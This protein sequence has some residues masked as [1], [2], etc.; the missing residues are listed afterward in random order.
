MSKLHSLSKLSLLH[1]IALLF[2]LSISDITPCYGQLQFSYEYG[3]G[4]DTENATDIVEHTFSMGSGQR[5]RKL[6]GI[7]SMD[8]VLSLST[9]NQA[10]AQQSDEKIKFERAILALSSEYSFSSRRVQPIIGIALGLGGESPENNEEDIAS[11]LVASGIGGIRV[12][13]TKTIAL[14]SMY[15]QTY[16]MLS[17]KSL[18]TTTKIVSIGL[19]IALFSKKTTL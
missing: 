4:A 12:Y 1:F 10:E 7:L 16:A 3:R 18:L 6:G 17:K 11:F 13:L 8:L 15:R 19:K 9:F 14:E 5:I 2:G